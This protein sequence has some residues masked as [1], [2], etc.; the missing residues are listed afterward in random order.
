[1]LRQGGGEE[2]G[3]DGQSDAGRGD[4]GDL[5]DLATPLEV[6]AD[7]QR[8][9][10]ARQPHA[11]TFEASQKKMP[12]KKKRTSFFKWKPVDRGFPIWGGSLPPKRVLCTE[13]GYFFFY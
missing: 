10:V 2:D 9:R 8:R 1:M 13:P 12:Q 7:H 6:L 5:D 3:H 4:Q 11:H